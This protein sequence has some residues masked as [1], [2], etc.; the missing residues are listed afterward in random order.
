MSMFYV[1]AWAL[2]GGAFFELLHWGGLKKSKYFPVYAGSK[3]YWVITVLMIT[4]GALLAVAIGLSGTGL[5]PLTANPFWLLGPIRHSETRQEFADA[6]I[7]NF[8]DGKRAPSLSTWF[9]DRVRH[10][11]LCLF[12]LVCLF[13]VLCKRRAP[14]SKGAH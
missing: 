13:Y 12:F 1:F 2:F 11:A 7:G 3:K 4:A 14:D 10:E 9:L 8:G 6:K 5:T